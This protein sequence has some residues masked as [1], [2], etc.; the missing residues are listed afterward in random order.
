MAEQKVV[1]KAEKK[2]EQK[3][4]QKAYLMVEQM[5]GKMDRRKAGMWGVTLADQMASQM[6]G[7]LVELKVQWLVAEMVDASESRK[8]ATSA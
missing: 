1:Q 2:V 3:V 6:V 5:A 7:N 4:V 8:A